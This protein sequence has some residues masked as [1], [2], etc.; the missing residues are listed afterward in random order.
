MNPN[1]SSNS[2]DCSKG[3]FDIPDG[4]SFKMGQQAPGQDL[5]S[6]QFDSQQASKSSQGFFSSTSS[7]FGSWLSKFT[8]GER[9]NI[10]SKDLNAFAPTSF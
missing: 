9:A 7:M 10:S 8:E 3:G 2:G 1:S 6:Q 4:S 5:S